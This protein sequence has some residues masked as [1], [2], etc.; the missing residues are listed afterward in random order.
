MTTKSNVERIDADCY[1]CGL[2]AGERDHFPSAKRNGGTHVLPI[3]VGCHE[4]KDRIGITRWSLP[5]LYNAISGVW[6]KADRNERLLLA[7]LLVMVEDAYVTLQEY[8]HELELDGFWRN[9][10]RGDDE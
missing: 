9:F 5:A 2:P 4:M 6:K 1:I 3:C 10:W 7:K 8:D